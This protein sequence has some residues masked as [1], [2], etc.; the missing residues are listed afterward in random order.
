MDKEVN[1]NL[2]HAKLNTY[3]EF[4]T[5]LGFFIYIFS[6]RFQSHPLNQANMNF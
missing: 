6:R 2:I 5:L 3:F 1:M 4:R